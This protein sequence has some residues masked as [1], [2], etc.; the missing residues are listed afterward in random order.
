MAGGNYLDSILDFKLI[1]REKELGI[2]KQAVQETIGGSGSTIMVSGEAGIGKSK[3]VDEF[4]KH[5]GSLDINVFAGAAAA[6]MAHPFLVFSKA[7]EKEITGPLFHDREF[8]SISAVFAVNRS[9]LLIGQASSDDNEN[10]DA[11][12][13][14]GM[15]S[16]V[17]NFVQDSF[18]SAGTQASGLGRLEYGNMKIIIKHGEHVFL[19]AVFK[20]IEHQ[21]MGQMLKSTID[22]IED[23][24]GHILEKWSG[25]M[26]EVSGIQKEIE[27]LAISRF[28]V[29]RDMEGIKLENERLRIA[30]LV[31]EKISQLCQKKPI[32]LLLE[33]LHWADESSLF[34]LNYLARNIAGN[35]MMILGTC[36]PKESQILNDFLEQMKDED[37]LE[38]IPLAKLDRRELDDLIDNLLSPNDLPVNFIDTLAARCD[39]NPFFVTE[40]LREMLV[41]G[42]ISP[43]DG[44]YA[45]TSKEYSIPSTVEEVVHMRLDKLEPD[46]MALIEYASCMGRTFDSSVA[47]AMPSLVDP[48]I[49][50]QKLIG[51]GILF[52]EN[53]Q[54][55][56]SHAILHD[57]TYQSIGQR[58][59]QIHHRSIG[60]YLEGQYKGVL[61]EILYDLARHYYL[62]KVNDK[63]YDYCCRAGEKAESAY[64][65]EDARNFYLNACSAQENIRASQDKDAMADILERIGDLDSLLGSYDDSIAR[66]SLSGEMASG[67][68][69]HAEIHKKTAEVYEKKAEFDRSLEE[70]EKGLELLGNAESLTRARLLMTQGKAH[71]MSG[72][73]D[74]AMAVLE[75]SLEL[76]QKLGG[77]MELG[78]VYGLMGMLNKSQGK[79][80]QGLIN[81]ETSLEI[82]KELKDMAGMS[83]TINNLGNLYRAKGDMKKALAYYKESLEIENKIG[84]PRGIAN[85]LNNLG[86]IYGDSGDRQVSVDHY[87]KAVKIFEKIGDQNGLATTLNN[88]GVAYHYDN[89][90][91]K[92]IEYYTKSLEMFKKIGNKVAVGLTHFN[93]ASI[94]SDNRK[95]ENAL[96]H[97]FTSI[98][99]V[100][101]QVD[102]RYLF[103][104]YCALSEAYIK[105]ENFDESII[106]GLKGKALA[107]EL[108]DDWMI[109]NCAL[110]MGIAHREKNNLD[111][112]SEL[113]E[114]ARDTLLNSEDLTDQARFYYEHG[115]LLRKKDQKDQAK[116]E[117]EK[118]LEYYEKAGNQLMCQKVKDS[119]KD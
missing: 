30:S 16:A 78:K 111:E 20:G 81:L 38:T 1:G 90:P 72:D 2:L 68:N 33:D 109:S 34:V 89:E 11:D 40:M 19:T 51:A 67:I 96:E 14:A 53:G 49:A 48:E 21:D 64:A 104:N 86:N 114:K 74:K 41:A 15:L 69:R 6:E 100:K 108:D 92:A 22:K 102:K 99:F 60:E 116:L 35:R 52:R 119:L 26:S 84:N 50:F 82:K 31:H 28:L 39:G 29:R 10:L 95:P 112:A 57:V 8:T 98:E 18:D 113:L 43:V 13:F 87:L 73:M 59:K 12:I 37:I 93:I 79:L 94:Y 77:D 117:F 4:K 88:V 24:Y 3:L 110:Y 101:N 36:R 70:A 63:A 91:E 62:G 42:A 32:L 107:D 61:D 27:A 45:L 118:S 66:Y 103:Y 17:Q 65:A 80:D 85:A 115:L 23:S 106:W 54:S 7:L 25:K 83:I 9:G 97:Y 47:L 46:A 56:F 5:A 75:E 58:W 76:A 71:M 105:L 44:K 55:S